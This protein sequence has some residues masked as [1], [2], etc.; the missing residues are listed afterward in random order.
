MLY[1]LSYE[2]LRCTFAW[3]PGES[4]FGG[5]GLATSLLTFCAAPVPCDQL[6]TPRAPAK[7]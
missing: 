1:P 3:I 5:L 7:S 6:L 4:P 2:G